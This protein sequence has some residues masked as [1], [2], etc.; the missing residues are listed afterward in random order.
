MAEA[1]LPGHVRRRA[2]RGS[3]RRGMSRVSPSS[4]HQRADVTF[5]RVRDPGDSRSRSPSRRPWA[6]GLLPALRFSRSEL[7]RRSRMTPAA[8]GGAWDGCRGSPRRPQAGAATVASWS[9]RPLFAL[10]ALPGSGR[11]P[12]PAL[13]STRR[14]CWWPTSGR[15]SSL[16]PPRHGRGGLSTWS[17]EAHPRGSPRGGPSRRCRAW[18]R[19]GGRHTSGPASTVTPGS[20]ARG[21]A[22][23]AGGQ[24]VVEAT[25]I[26]EGYFAPSDVLVSGPR[27]PAHG[28]RRVRARGG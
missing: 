8:A 24:V 14:G 4:W 20:P 16:P 7:V 17:R 10:A 3:R 26:T 2:R 19:R 27:L 11:T 6:F 12:S 23:E 22:D 21:S 13:G 15:G 25:T 18:S 28:R 9:C 5:D 1:V